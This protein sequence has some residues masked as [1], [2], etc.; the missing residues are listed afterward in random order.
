GT[1]NGWGITYELSYQGK[2][3]YTFTKTLSA[4]SY[5]FKV[6]SEDWSTVDYGGTGEAPLATVG[7][8]TS[9]EAIGANIALNITE[10]GNYTFKVIGPDREN[11]SILIDKQ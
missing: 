11:V 7:Q 5:E 9:L 2:G 1:L 10:Q 6:A 3:I 8:L 4:A